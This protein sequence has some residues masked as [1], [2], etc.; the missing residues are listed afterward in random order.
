MTPWF[1]PDW[2]G[3][4][5]NTYSVDR[6][7]IYLVRSN[8][9]ARAS[10]GKYAEAPNLYDGEHLYLK[11]GM[12][13]RCPPFPPLLPARN[14]W[15]RFRL[16]SKSV[17]GPEHGYLSFLGMLDFLAPHLQDVNFFISADEYPF[18]FD[19]I[20]IVCGNLQRTRLESRYWINL[21]DASDSEL[22]DL[23][24]EAANQSEKTGQRYL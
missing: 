13:L 21:D 22:L 15:E 18:F 2:D 20:R 24:A 11:T 7:C 14:R 9:T 1:P 4:E 3:K 5:A 10:L 8:E 12:S 19:N 6:Y 23:Q 16:T 17:S